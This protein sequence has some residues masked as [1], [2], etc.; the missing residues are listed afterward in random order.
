MAPP[1]PRHL[2]HD[3]HVPSDTPSTGAFPRVLARIGPVAGA[4]VGIAILFFATRGLAREGASW[5]RAA[6]EGAVIALLLGGVVGF[7]MLQYDALPY[8]LIWRPVARLG[9][10]GRRG[11]LVVSAIAAAGVALLLAT[12]GAAAVVV[13]PA[14]FVLLLGGWACV[15][16]DRRLRTSRHPAVR[17]LPDVL[18]AVALGGC[19]IVLFDRD[20][21]TTQPAAGALFPVAAW[22]SLRIWRAMLGSRRLVVRAGADIVL[23]LLL[24]TD[25]LLVIVWAANLFQ[26]APAEVG[27]LRAVL[28]HTGGAMELPWQF[29]LALYLALAAATAFFMVGATDGTR[30]AR[31]LSGIRSA[32]LGRRLLGGVHIGLMVTVL[33]AMAAPAALNKTLPFESRYRI[34]VRRE[35]TATGAEA[36]YQRIRRQFTATPTPRPAPLAAI[37]LK[38]HRVSPPRPGSRDATETERHLARYVGRLQADAVVFASP[39][40]KPLPTSTPNGGSLHERLDRLNGEQHRAAVRTSQAHKLAELAAI[41]VAGTLQ[42]PDIGRNEIIQ[43]VRE[44]L[45][46]LVEGG[47]LKDVF[48]A[49]AR[50]VPIP[51]RLFPDK[52]VIP[53]VLR[54]QL[55]ASRAL[56]RRLLASHGRAFIP[57]TTR[58]SPNESPGD[59]A[60]DLANQVRYFDEGTGPCSDCA[61]PFRP[62]EEPRLPGE[63]L[64]FR[65]RIP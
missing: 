21:L 64:P 60:V 10:L 39:L 41:T 40:P 36:A 22:L 30:W 14:T 3:G 9:R 24:G 26:L 23:S 35:L 27:T 13:L 1:Y 2:R 20:L 51:D 8:V 53:D 54:L 52:V 43:I 49:W 7:Y 32:D 16:L 4:G 31:L 5:W 62:G 59:R 19:L 11:R 65:P 56:V 50:R 46:G 6:L 44:Y 58:R 34:D 48:A 18:A 17:I 55:A 28:E 25:L 15:L 47:P 12:V 45:G 63:H 37:V 61:R 29:W 42:I 33:I 38:I 57:P